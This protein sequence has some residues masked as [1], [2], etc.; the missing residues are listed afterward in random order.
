M[1]GDIFQIQNKNKRFEG[2]SEF[3]KA[4]KDKENVLVAHGMSGGRSS[5]MHSSFVKIIPSS[6]VLKRPLG[7]RLCL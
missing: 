7:F 4:G 3:T 6:S 1:L 5:F 2:Q